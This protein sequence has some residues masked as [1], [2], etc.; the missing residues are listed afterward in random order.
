MIAVGQR[1]RHRKQAGWG[2]GVVTQ[3][4]TAGAL[5]VLVIEFPGGE[6]R[7]KLAPEAVGAMIEVL[8]ADDHAAHDARQAAAEATAKADAKARTKRTRSRKHEARSRMAGNCVALVDGGDGHV[9]LAIAGDG[10]ECL[11]VCRAD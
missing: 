7:L 4:S 5:V 8:S 11:R 2:V 10:A 1:V 6:R 9:L 3:T